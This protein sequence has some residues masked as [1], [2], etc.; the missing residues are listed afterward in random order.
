MK[1]LHL[2]S[3]GCPKN[4]VD[5]ERILTQLRAEGY[6]LSPSYDGADLVIADPPYAFD[7]WLELLDGLEPERVLAVG[8]SQ[9]AVRL[10]T[11]INAVHPVARAYDGFL[12]AARLPKKTDE[13]KAARLEAIELANAAGGVAVIA[14]PATIA[15]RPE[16]RMTGAG[17][18]RRHWTG[19]SLEIAFLLSILD[20]F[21]RLLRRRPHLFVV[22]GINYA[23]QERQCRLISRL[24]QDM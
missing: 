9:S 24:P 12:V 1:R 14:H 23:L 19:M 6:G 18:V 13:E 7:G 3:L 22:T 10:S 11:Y 2:V 17:T 8:G 20:C 4:L 21:D 5:S 16:N 15:A